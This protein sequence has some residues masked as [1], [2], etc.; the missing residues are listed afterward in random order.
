MVT[1]NLSLYLMQQPTE[2]LLKDDSELINEPHLPWK[3][4]VGLDVILSVQGIFDKYQ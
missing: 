2:K 4:K 1:D 3:N